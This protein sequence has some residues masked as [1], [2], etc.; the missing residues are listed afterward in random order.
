MMQTR[1]KSILDPF[2]GSN[3]L[4]GSILQS[5]S[6]IN[7]TTTINHLLGR[8]PN[9]WL[10]VDIDASANIYRSQPFNNLT[11]TLTSDAACIVNLYIF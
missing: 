3:F 5:I 4:N 6:L 9:G 7:G 1:W 2:L 8:T 11:L 10:L